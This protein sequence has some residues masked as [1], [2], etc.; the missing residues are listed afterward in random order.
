MN[1]RQDFG[2]L[3]D[4]VSLSSVVSLRG[5]RRDLCEAESGDLR[6]ANDGESAIARSQTPQLPP[7]FSV[8]YRC[9]VD[10]GD[11]LRRRS[12]SQRSDPCEADVSDPF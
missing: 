10:V 4:A 11:G 5:G 3:H 6:E 1:L 9:A 12:A 7:N 8:V 2:Q